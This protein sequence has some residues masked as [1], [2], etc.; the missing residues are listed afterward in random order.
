[1]LISIILIKKQ[2]YARAL[3]I[4]LVLFILGQIIGYGFNVDLLKTIVPSSSDV[5]NVVGY[6]VLTSTIFPLIIAFS[7]DF[8]Y[9]LF[10]TNKS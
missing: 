1:M 2:F 3:K 4:F 10:E 6:Q 9:K 8:I 7:L 5:K